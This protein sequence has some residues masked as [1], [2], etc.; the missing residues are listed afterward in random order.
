MLT[1][2]TRYGLQSAA[3]KANELFERLKPA[4]DAM[5][6][7]GSIRRRAATVKDIELVVVPLPARGATLFD[8]T[9]TIGDP[10]EQPKNRVDLLV[11]RLI[12][13]GFVAWDDELKRRGRRYKR[14]RFGTLPV[15]LFIV[16]RD[17]FGLQLALRTGPAEFSKRLV[18]QQWKEGW[19]PDD[20]RVQD[21]RLYRA[22]QRVAVPTE[23]A[24]FNAIELTYKKP[25]AR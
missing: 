17:S 7:A 12:A 18:T 23:A 14:L 16:E 3:E 19:L 2:P 20:M 6:V 24:F 11:E 25:E 15:D 1:V 13:E 10:F 9:A 4:C 21:G 5:S 22:G 8:A